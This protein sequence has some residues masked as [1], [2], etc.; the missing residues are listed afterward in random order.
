MRKEESGFPAKVKI[1]YGSSSTT[2]GRHPRGLIERLVWREAELDLLNPKIH[3]I[4]IAGRVGERKRLGI[5][6]KAKE[7]NFHIANPGKEET[8]PVTEAS[9]EEEKKSAAEF[10]APA[11]E[12]DMQSEE[13]NAS[14]GV[15]AKEDSD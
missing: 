9:R 12:P 14:E 7:Q 4:R 11:E 13:G 5:I 15:E 3:I 6:T 10:E 2:R 1:G 8:R